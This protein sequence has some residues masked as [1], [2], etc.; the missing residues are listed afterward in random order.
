MYVWHSGAKSPSLALLPV[1]PLAGHCRSTVYLSDN[2]MS[3]VLCSDM[4]LV[5]A[6]DDGQSFGVWS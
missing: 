5:A 3:A 1:S 6:I 2:D 4:R